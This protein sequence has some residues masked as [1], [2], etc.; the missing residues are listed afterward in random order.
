M[1]LSSFVVHLSECRRQ[2]CAIGAL[3]FL[4]HSTQA[5][6][7]NL[8]LYTWIVISNILYSLTFT[9]KQGAAI[10]EPF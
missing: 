2:V 1:Y 3:W 9:F 5:V 7:R 4:T 8:K 6:F 10:S